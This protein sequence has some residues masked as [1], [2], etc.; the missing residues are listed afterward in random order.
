MLVSIKFVHLS[1]TQKQ[2]FEIMNDIK[3]RF[4]GNGYTADSGLDTADMETF[5]KDA[6]K[7]KNDYVSAEEIKVKQIR[8][9]WHPFEDVLVQLIYLLDSFSVISF[10]FPLILHTSIMA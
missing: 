6:E 9:P 5:K 10:L 7:A 4:P 8:S 3:W 1:C 2:F